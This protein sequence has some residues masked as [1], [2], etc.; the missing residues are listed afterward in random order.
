MAKGGKRPGAG[1]KKGVPNRL[2]GELKDMILGA[3]EDAGG[4]EYLQK[5]A[6]ENPVAFLSLLGRVLPLQVSGEGGGAVRVIVEKAA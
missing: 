4:R 6:T 1:R 2:T 3:L 5:R